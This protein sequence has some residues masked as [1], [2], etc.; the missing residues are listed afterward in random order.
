MLWTPTHNFKLPPNPVMERYVGSSP[1]IEKALAALTKI[2]KD[3]NSKSALD[4]I[5][6]NYTDSKE[7]EIICR[8]FEK[9]FGFH[10][11]ELFWSN[12]SIPNAFTMT[13]GALIN[14]SPG[15]T[16]SVL[17]NKG[18]RYYDQ[19]HTYNCYV[20]VI[21]DFIRTLQMT[22]RE[23]MSVL[24]HEIGHNFDNLWTT[25]VQ[26]GVY[27]F[28]GQLIIP[29]IIKA[30][31]KMIF[32]GWYA[33][34]KAFPRFA[35]AVDVITHLPYHLSIVRIPNFAAL[36]DI[37]NPFALMNLICGTRSEYYSDAFA[38]SY[39]FGPDFASSTMKM[40]D[41]GKLGGAAE[42]V[43]YE[44]PV[45]RSLL[46]CIMGPLN[47]LIGLID[48]HPTDENRI[49]AI[50]QS[51]END[52]NDPH[53]P[54]SLKPEIKRQIQTIDRYIEIDA[55]ENVEKGLFFQALIKYITYNSP[56]KYFYHR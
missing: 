46:D 23:A 13:G 39:G 4:L 24:L 45:I 48:P 41:R 52:L 6:A 28:F 19:R 37:A 5:T 40:S 33:V 31:Y 34:Q 18:K 56:V 7:N 22:P 29:D 51:L 3:I 47:L 2:V 49:L 44:I 54:S 12:E 55:Q 35:Y 20:V 8:M 42:R 1:N 21:T 53:T 10:K 50:R 26:Y 30:I 9:E 36:R 11:M 38:A 16:D 43:V 32:Q 25:Q 15:M 17:D 27:M 14:A